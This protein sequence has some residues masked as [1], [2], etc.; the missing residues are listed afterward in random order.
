MMTT[1]RGDVVALETFLTCSATFLLLFSFFL[2]LLPF[3]FP[4]SFL[5]DVFRPQISL[6]SKCVHRVRAKAR[7]H[8]SLLESC[9]GFG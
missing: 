1:V 6:C 2:F 8:V 5:R 4:L 7:H 3:L 9:L